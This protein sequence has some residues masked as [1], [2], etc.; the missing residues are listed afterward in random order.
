MTGDERYRTA[1]EC[2]YAAFA[3]Y[4]RNS[5]GGFWHGRRLPGEMWIDGV[6]MG[7][8]FLSRYGEPDRATATPVST[9]WP[10]QIVSFADALS[11]GR[12]GAV[13]AR[14]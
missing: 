1:A 11:Q 7:G 2:V 4:P 3:D 10:R 13:S 12:Y 8:M 14:L 5:D 6:F 9:R